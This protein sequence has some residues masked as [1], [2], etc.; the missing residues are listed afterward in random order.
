MKMSAM[1]CCF[2]DNSRIL[3]WQ[4]TLKRLLFSMECVRLY[5]E[6]DNILVYFRN[7]AKV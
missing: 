4:S 1:I 6:S 2:R 3:F 7:G 5:L